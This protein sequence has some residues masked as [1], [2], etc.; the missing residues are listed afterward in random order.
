MTRV[1]ID[2]ALAAGATDAVVKIFAVLVA[3]MRADERDAIDKFG[4]GIE[5]ISSA[6]EAARAKAAEIVPE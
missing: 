4:A 5:L 1:Q 2:S 6:H 3:G